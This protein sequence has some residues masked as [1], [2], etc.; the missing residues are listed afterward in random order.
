[1]L[2]ILF[3]VNNKGGLRST[4]PLKKL[5]TI[6]LNTF[7]KLM[8]K[9]RDLESRQNNFYHKNSVLQTE[10]FLSRYEQ[11]EKEVINM[12]D[13][14][15]KRQILENRERIRPIIET[16]I[17]LARQNIPLRGHRDDGDLLASL[18][19]SVINE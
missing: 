19:T 17:F 3:L 13:S 6:P 2:C 12:I 8:G 15:K 11:P 1:M 4:E 16:I 14:E 5:I 10:E 18:N 9:D 7:A